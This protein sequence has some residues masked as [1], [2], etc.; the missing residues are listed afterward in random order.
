V[1][2]RKKAE[3][4]DANRSEIFTRN[5]IKKGDPTYRG[6]LELASQVTH[7][8]AQ[9]RLDLDEWSGEQF[10]HY[11]KEMNK[12]ISTMAPCEVAQGLLMES[13]AALFGRC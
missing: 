4:P 3:I 6:M 2:K 8:Y 13:P 1:A 11:K 7:I 12:A 10:T 5:T 9:E